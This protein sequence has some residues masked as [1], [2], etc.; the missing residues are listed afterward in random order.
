MTVVHK[1]K[2]LALFTVVPEAL[3]AEE[4]FG[5]FNSSHEGLGVLLEEFRELEDA[6]RANDRQGVVREA[7]QVASVA[8]RIVA[9]CDL[10]E[11][12]E[13]SGMEQLRS[14]LAESS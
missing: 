12:R 10:P 5:R 14:R 1:L 3:R 8:L 7:T 4:K 6:I 13:H 11:F 2:D 9:C